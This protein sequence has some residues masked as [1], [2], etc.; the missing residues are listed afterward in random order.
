M[1]E[2]YIN[3]RLLAPYC[4]YINIHNNDF[5]KATTTAAKQQLFLVKATI[6]ELPK[7]PTIN[8]M[9]YINKNI[10]MS[11]SPDNSPPPSPGPNSPDRDDPVPNPVCLPHRFAL[12][13]ANLG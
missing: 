6:Y 12:L 8:N 2:R 10:V 5:H 7:Q 4:S 9:R 11:G 1:K 3:R 13:H